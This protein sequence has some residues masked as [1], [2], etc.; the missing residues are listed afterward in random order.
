MTVAELKAQIAADIDEDL[1][2]PVYYTAAEQLAALNEAQQIF[3]L[4]TLCL[5]T[6]APF[7]FIAGKPRYR[8]RGYL[9]DFLLPL[10]VT[11]GGQRLKPA[12]INDLDALSDSWEATPGTPARYAQLGFS[13]LAV[14]PQPTETTAGAITYARSA[15]P[16]VDDSSEA[17]IPDDQQNA[18]A[19]YAYCYL[20]CKDGGAEA[21]QQCGDRLNRFIA[22]C[23]KLSKYVRARSQ[24]GKYDRQPAELSLIDLSRMVVKGNK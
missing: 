16:L 14:T 24:A 4:L 2:A 10:K 15:A 19:D 17:E 3:C 18:L 11:V 6:T 5:E 1:G 23:Q 22:S 12:R 9:N 8:L 21:M 20:R 13:Y 7:T